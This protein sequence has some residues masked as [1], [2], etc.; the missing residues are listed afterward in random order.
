MSKGWAKE[1]PHFTYDFETK[2]S[3]A[4]SDA[5]NALDCI[6][7]TNNPEEHTDLI[8][9]YIKL[10][11]RI[12]KSEQWVAKYDA[13]AYVKHPR[14]CRAPPKPKISVTSALLDKK[15]NVFFK[16]A[17]VLVGQ[18]AFLEKNKKKHLKNINIQVKQTRT[19]TGGVMFRI[20]QK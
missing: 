9:Q 8:L 5:R 15:I 11:V 20:V 6:N 4:L 16:D 10:I 2:K 7:L 17:M 14:K 13:K 18:K 12:Q 3:W 19:P 1:T